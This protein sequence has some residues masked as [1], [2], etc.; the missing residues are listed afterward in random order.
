MHGFWNPGEADHHAPLYQRSWEDEN[1]TSYVDYSVNYLIKKGMPSDMINLGIPLYGRTWTMA[2]LA[3]VDSEPP[4]EAEGPGDG[5]DFTMQPGF[6]GYHEICYAVK[7]NGWEVFDDPDHLNGPYAV[8]PFSPKT[9]VGYDDP[10]MAAVK[11]N[12][13][14]DNQ[15]GGSMVWDIST[16]DFANLCGGGNNPIMKSVSETMGVGTLTPRGRFVC[17]FPNWAGYR[18]GIA[19]E[20]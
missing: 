1:S 6:L 18:S 12:Y 16:D 10:E 11:A 15:L 13:V 20:C 19:L 9:W 3:S 2:T 4:A 17:Y 7:E 8:S 5:G 14:I